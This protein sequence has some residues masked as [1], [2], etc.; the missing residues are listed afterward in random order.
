M[1]CYVMK[2]VINY[3]YEINDDEYEINYDYEY[4]IKYVQFM[5]HYENHCMDFVFMFR[6]W[7]SYYY[8]NYKFIFI[9]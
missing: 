4:Y 3:D 1:V 5:I 7:H 6:L 9:F 2:I 8:I